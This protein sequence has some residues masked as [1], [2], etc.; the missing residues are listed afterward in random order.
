VFAQIIEKILGQPQLGLLLKA[1]EES[2][3]TKLKLLV[4]VLLGWLAWSGPSALAQGPETV[5]VAGDFQAALGCAE[6]WQPA[7]RD[8]A[9]TFDEEDGVWQAEFDLPAGDYNYKAALDAGWDANYGAKAVPDGPNIPLPLADDTTVKFY[10]DDQTHWITD[11]QT[12]LIATLAGSFQSELGCTSGG[13]SGDWDPACLRSWLQDPDGDGIYIFVTADLPAGDYEAKVAI[14]ES[15]DENYGLGGEPNGGNIAFSVPDEGREMTFAYDAQAH[16]LGISVAEPPD[17]EAD[18]ELVRPPARHPIQDSIFYFLLPDRFNNGNP[19]NDRAGLTPD[20]PTVHGFDPTHKGFYHGGD[21][22]GLLEQMDYLEELGVTAIWLAPVFK[23]Q[24]YNPRR[25]DAGYHGYW[26]TDFTQFD[27][28]F[29]TNEEFQQVVD[30]A[31]SRG[32]KVIFDIIM[33]HTADVIQYAEDE[34]AYI[35]KAEQPYRDAEGNPFDDRDYAGQPDFPDLDPEASFPYTPVFTTEADA[36]L[37]APDWLNN[38]IY[39][40][41]RGDSSFIDENSLYGDFDRLDDLFT[42]HPDVVNGLID[43]YKGWVDFGV[44]GFRV[45]TVKH[46]NVELWQQFVPALLAY[47]AEQGNPDFFIFGEV[48]SGD[49]TL[50]SYYTTT[51]QL[52]AVLDFGFQGTA[53]A[54]VSQGEPSDRLKNFFEADDRYTDADSSAQMLPNFI[55]NH[56][57]G[58]FG[59]FLVQDE[60]PEEEWVERSLLGHA[61][62]YFS[63]GLPVIYYGDEQGFTGDGNDQDAREDMFPSQVESYNDNDLIGAEATT[64]DDNFDQ[65]HPLY[66][67]LATYAELYAAHPALRRG[68]QIH[69]FSSSEPGVYAFSRIDR[70]ERVEFVLG[71]NNITETLTVEV[72]T[73]YGEGV[74]F[75]PL[76]PEEAEP[77]TTGEDGRLS[78]TVPAIGFTIYQ[79]AEPVPP[80]ESAPKIKLSRPLNGQAVDLV[81]NSIDGNQ[82]VERLL[83]EAAVET[84]DFV[85]VTFAARV[86]DGAY[87]PIGTDDNPPYRAF[88]DATQLRGQEAASLSFKAIVNTLS[89][90]DI[91]SDTINSAEVIGIVPNI[92]E[93]AELDTSIKYAI[94]HYRRA[95]GDYGDPTDPA[96]AWSVN[97]SG[98][99]LDPSVDPTQPQPLIGETDFGRFA[100]VR[101]AD[102]SQPLEFS[103]QQGE[104][105]AVTGLSFVPDEQPE[106]WLVEGDET[107]YD[108]PVAAQDFIPVH[109]QNESGDYADVTLDVVVEDGTALAEGLEPIEEADFGAYFEVEAP[110]ELSQPLQMTVTDDGAATI[111]EAVFVPAETPTV[112][113]LAGDPTIYPSRGAAEDFVAIHYHRPDGDY[114]DATSSDFNDFW[115]LHTFGGAADPGWETPRVPDGQDAFGITFI[116]PHDEGADGFGYIIHR[117]NS[118]DPFYAGE[119]GEGPNMQIHMTRYGHEVWHVPVEYESRA[120]FNPDNPPPYVYPV[121]GVPQGGAE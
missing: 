32:I 20:D 113:L 53:R 83:V 119:G 91:L 45:D 19:A 106:V 43:I 14:A 74:E 6:D 42:E 35:S 121:T 98:E 57:M 10:Y 76:W 40:H 58:R 49:D 23:N 62:M 118:K 60:V 70:E 59:L 36:T 24:P 39:Y 69:R 22:A 111:E 41:N 120:A 18:I 94:V 79:A 33:N 90:S 93:P 102:P 71:F 101:L 4:V 104:T 117:G 56:D 100:W 55:G 34:Y 47:A 16:A 37:K 114:G 88:F 87:E 27:P 5:T 108:S 103:I 78:L 115:G 11:N 110:G 82:V 99:G 30:E 1:Y 3:M 65:T 96:G 64:A 95:D 25:D 105:E 21:L 51:G 107:L 61:L 68:A 109:Y 31:H 86:N 81:V 75:E 2:T 8:T 72:P 13:D 50:L 44:D 52:P 85:E 54:Y 7:C 48:F 15:W 38:P 17:L 46:V 28:H 80:S 73:F 84:D 66:T 12:G 63:R 116:V 92:Q 29:G 67:T 97:F 89:E 77:L 9:L 112:W 26:V